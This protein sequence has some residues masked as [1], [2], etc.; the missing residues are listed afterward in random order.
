MFI[1]ARHE[2]GSTLKRKYIQMIVVY[3]GRGLAKVVMVSRAYG[4]MTLTNPLVGSYLGS[5]FEI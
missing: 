5:S 2:T 4:S 3:L 1:V